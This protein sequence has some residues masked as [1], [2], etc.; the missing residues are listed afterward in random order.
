MNKITEWIKSRLFWLRTGIDVKV[1]NEGNPIDQVVIRY[2]NFFFMIDIDVESGE[3]TGDFGWSEGTPMTPVP[4]RE[5]YKAVKGSSRC[6]TGCQTARCRGERNDSNP[7]KT[8]V[9]LRLGH[10]VAHP[11]KRVL[12]TKHDGEQFV[13]KFKEKTGR[14]H[15]FMDHERVKSA[16]IRQISILTTDY[17]PEN[18]EV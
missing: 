15:F 11:G 16:S 14:F 9:K 3:P 13:A 7:E 17:K 5:H 18:K 12:V 10:T 8:P 4:I 2:K 6:D 1:A